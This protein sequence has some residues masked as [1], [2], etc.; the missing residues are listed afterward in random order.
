LKDIVK[1]SSQIE[2]VVSKEKGHPIVKGE[3]GNGRE[4]VICVR[5][6]EPREIIEKIQLLKNSSG[7]RLQKYIHPVHSTNPSVRGVWSPFHVPKENRFRI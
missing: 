1:D 4:K 7:S 6:M 2:F 3:Y 5:N